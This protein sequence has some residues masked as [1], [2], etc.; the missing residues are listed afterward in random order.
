M[1]KTIKNSKKTNITQAHWKKPPKKYC[2]GTLITHTRSSDKYWTTF[3]P[4]FFPRAENTR[5][6]EMLSV[7][8]VQ[9]IILWSPF[10][11]A[12]APGTRKIERMQ[13]EVKVHKGGY[14][15]NSGKGK[16]SGWGFVPLVVRRSIDF[17]QCDMGMVF[18]TAGLDM[19]FWVK[20]VM[21]R[22]LRWN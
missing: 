18:I 12:Q 20:F 1:K 21:L 4:T 5:A 7:T 22:W 9:P 2:T 10:R 17:E 13:S 6:E 8:A 11:F 15:R 16:F 19:L 14:F 3:A